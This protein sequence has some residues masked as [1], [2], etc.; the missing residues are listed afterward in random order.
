MTHK[1][2]QSN[3]VFDSELLESKNENKDLQSICV[4][5]NDVNKVQIDEQ[6]QQEISESEPMEWIGNQGIPPADK[7]NIEASTPMAKF[8]C[9]H[10]RLGHI[11]FKKMRRMA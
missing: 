3:V 5:T 7:P 6:F 4:P 10:Y 2:Q 1:I 9:W 11:H 8:M